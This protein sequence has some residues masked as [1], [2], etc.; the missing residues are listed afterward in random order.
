MNFLNHLILLLYLINPV[1]ASSRS[2][3][4][5]EQETIDTNLVTTTSKNI[6]IP[7]CLKE[8]KGC[9]IDPTSL[10]EDP[11]KANSWEICQTTC[12]FHPS[13]NYLVWYGAASSPFICTCF[14]LNQKCDPETEC[15][16]CVSGDLIAKSE[17]SIN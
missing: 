6:P 4:G 7:D 14:L 12:Q 17:V 10:V 13:C 5:N 1:P 16:G 3:S 11:F 2:K 15:L 8:D 9:A